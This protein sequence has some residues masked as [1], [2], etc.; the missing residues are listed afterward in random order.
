MIRSP[1]PIAASLL[2]L[3]GCRSEPEPPPGPPPVD[4]HLEAQIQDLIGQLRGHYEV[5]QDEVRTQLV[6]VG[7]PAVRYLMR[8]CKNEDPGV[9]QQ[10]ALALAEIGDPEGIPAILPLVDDPDFRV[11][12]AACRSLGDLGGPEAGEPYHGWAGESLF[13]CLRADSFDQRVAAAE[14]IRRAH[15][16]PAIPRLIAQMSDPDPEARIQA[17][18]ALQGITF[19]NFRA[20]IR[21]WEAWWE[22]VKLAADDAGLAQADVFHFFDHLHATPEEIERAR[23]WEQEAKRRLQGVEKEEDYFDN[24]LDPNI[25]KAR[26]PPRLQP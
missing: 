1:I 24:P 4:A 20:D 11:R 18:D 2:L 17:E 3:A 21:A 19:R 26:H 10:S 23:L 5:R 25:E 16:E 15:Y 13:K 6:L 12:I 9:R 22:D 8:A 14:G 7:R